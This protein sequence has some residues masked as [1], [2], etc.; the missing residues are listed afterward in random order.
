MSSLSVFCRPQRIALNDNQVLPLK[1]RHLEITCLSGLLWIT[2]G[3]GGDRIVREGQ[4]VTLRS[5]S[6]ICVQAFAASVVRI[7]PMAPAAYGKERQHD[8]SLHD[9]AVEC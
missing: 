1:G 7:R 5:K 3:V 2:D 6:S 4:Q 9:A 8:R